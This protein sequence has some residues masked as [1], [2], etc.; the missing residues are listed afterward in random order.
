MVQST[1][2]AFLDQSF[3]PRN[4]GHLS[5]RPWFPSKF[6]PD[7]RA[8]VNSQV[9]KAGDRLSGLAKSKCSMSKPVSY[10]QVNASHGDD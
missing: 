1:H 4:V 3:P 7:S 8:Y 2:L 9:G 10:F 5:E 6:V